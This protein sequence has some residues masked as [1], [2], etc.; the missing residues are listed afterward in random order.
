MSL[1]IA[2]LRIASLSIASLRS[3]DALHRAGA[4]H[5]AEVHY[6]L[7]ADSPE[8]EQQ[9]GL[10]QPLLAFFLTDKL[11]FYLAGTFLSHNELLP[12]PSL[13]PQRG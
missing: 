2:S 10:R 3:A 9:A 6:D 1:R 13:F 7:E 8:A 11:E 4:L 5:R 12:P